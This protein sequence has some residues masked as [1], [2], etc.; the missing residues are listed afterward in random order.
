MLL[1]TQDALLLCSHMGRVQIS[2]SQRWVSVEGRAV[3][4]ATDP[5]SKTIYP[6]PNLAM[7]KPCTNS[8]AVQHGYSAFVRIDGHAVCRADLVGVTDGMPPGAAFY[9]V[10]QP[11]QGLVSETP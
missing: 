11:G 4:V 2:P 10:S 5:E 6:C 1:L 3:L 7:G 8:L 9:R